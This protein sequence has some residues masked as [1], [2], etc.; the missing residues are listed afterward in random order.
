MINRSSSSCL[1]PCIDEL[2]CGPRPILLGGA[3]HSGSL[4]CLHHLQEEAVPPWIVG[5]LGVKG[6]AQ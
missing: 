2:R 1:S 5:Q 6:A 4:M 3:S